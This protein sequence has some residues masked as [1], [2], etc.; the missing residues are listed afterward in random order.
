VGGAARAGEDRLGG[1]RPREAVGQGH[2]LAGRV[3]PL[4]ARREGRDLG[5]AGL[6]SGRI[7]DG[8]A[9]TGGV[10]GGHDGVDSETAER[11]VVEAMTKLPDGGSVAEPA[12]LLHW[13]RLQH[14]QEEACAW[15]E[16]SVSTGSSACCASARA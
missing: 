14:P 6:R 16:P 2:P 15:T 8:H 1:G 9:G 4:V 5:G 10:G 3:A 12:H 13:Q 7:G 11:V